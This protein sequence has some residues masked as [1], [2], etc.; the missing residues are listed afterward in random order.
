VTDLNRL[1][2]AF[3]AGNDA[4]F[5]A[6]Y[7]D[8]NPRL[9]AYCHKLI[10][11]RA[12]SASPRPDDLMQ[13]LWERVI[14]L[15]SRAG[16]AAPREVVNPSAFLF[17]MLKNLA[18]DAHRRKKDEISLDEHS[19]QETHESHGIFEQET[20][21][22]E[23]IIL[24]ALEKLPDD[25]REVLILNIYSGYSFGEITT[26]VGKSTEA[27]W[28]QASRARVKLRTIVME[29]AVRMGVAIPKTNGTVND[30]RNKIKI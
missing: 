12:G 17:R 3:L 11:S 27:I 25:D 24:E 1:F 22:I 23:A 5:T 28:Q 2:E 14:G 4:A 15:R 26:M 8:L 9:S 7:R 20:S 13:E 16:S 18:I 30:K 10:G 29:D 6:L 19:S 21:D